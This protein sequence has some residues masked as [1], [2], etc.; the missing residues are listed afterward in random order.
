MNYST[1]KI[2]RVP[3][4]G[5]SRPVTGAPGTG[6]A[7]Q[8]NRR[9]DRVRPR[10]LGGGR[11]R[12]GWCC[13]SGRHP[14]CGAH[15]NPAHPRPVPRGARSREHPP[16]PDHPA[17]SCRESLPS[18]AAA[19]VPPR[20]RRRQNLSSTARRDRQAPLRRIARTAYRSS[21]ASSW[22]ANRIARVSFTPGADDKSPTKRARR[23]SDELAQTRRWPGENGADAG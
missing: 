8:D 3:G 20:R 1:T 17:N 16:E 13:S 12:P 9:A 2:S 22:L 11:D 7:Y 18:H 15:V 10:F 5:A 19:A 21:S 6:T 14:R 4:K 23:A